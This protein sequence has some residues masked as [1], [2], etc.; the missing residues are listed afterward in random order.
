MRHLMLA[1][2][3]IGCN[4]TNESPSKRKIYSG[5]HS[6]SCQ[7]IYNQTY[8]CEN[9]EVVCYRGFNGSLQCKFRE[10]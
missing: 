8:R 4:S 1:L 7:L 6:F 5:Q 9:N 3:L 2:L 10:N